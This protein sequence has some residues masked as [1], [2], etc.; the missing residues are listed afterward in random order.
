[1]YATEYV[2]HFGKRAEQSFDLIELRKLI[3]S[4]S[5]KNRILGQENYNSLLLAKYRASA[6][7]T[8]PSFV[9]I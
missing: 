4:H 7:S 5:F 3:V 2:D 6:K 8:A 1:M 9:R